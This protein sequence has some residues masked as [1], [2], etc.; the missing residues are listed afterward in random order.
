MT[1][2]KPTTSKEELTVNINPYV[3]L[4]TGERL[5]S[6]ALGE[7]AA[8]EALEQGKTL[9]AGECEAGKYTIDANGRKWK[10]YYLKDGNEYIYKAQGDTVNITHIMAVMYSWDQ[11]QIRGDK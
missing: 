10:A 9:T 4:S 3:T 1:T 7:A 5:Y 11:W 8:S 6:H 2:T